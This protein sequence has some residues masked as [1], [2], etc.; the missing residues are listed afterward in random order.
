MV[1]RHHQDVL[2]VVARQGHE[3][4]KVCQGFSGDGDIGQLIHDHFGGLL[5]CALVKTDVDVGVARAQLGE[6]WG[7]DIPRLGVGGGNAQ[8][9][10]VLGVEFLTNFLQ[11]VELAKY[12]LDAFD[13]LGSWW[14]DALE[15]LAVS[16]KDFNAELRFKLQNGFRNTGLGGVQGLSSQCQVEVVL[17]RLVDEFELMKV[18]NQI[19]Y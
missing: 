8:G 15:S 5:R 19:L 17:D 1:R 12:H 10:A 14:G 3:F 13:H 11:I 16:S 6:H 4:V 7:Q 2:P 18:H 9:A